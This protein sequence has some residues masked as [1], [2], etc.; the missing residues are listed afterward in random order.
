MALSTD[1]K[2]DI[3]SI[4]KKAGVWLS[5]HHILLY[6]ALAIAG[7]FGVYAIE[8]KIASVAEAKAEAAQ[9]ALAVEKDH[10]A[11]LTAA[12]AT[13]QTQR[14]KENAAF[15]QTISL[16]QSQTKVQIVHDK[17][18]PAPEL[19]HRIE[20]LTGF[21]QDTITLDASQDLIVPLPL[22][23][24]ITARL[25]QGAA[26]AQTVTQQTAVIKNQVATIAEQTNIIT[27]DK[28]VLD[29]TIKA[30]ATE[31]TKV[32][33]DARKSKLKWFGAGVVVGFVG[34]QFAKF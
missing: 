2:T 19:G 30:D 32:K 29:K 7:F 15:L 17:A 14:D 3:Q 21:K 23:Q 5:A 28:A 4:E 18:L 24:D 34:R 12:F 25:D 8:S 31:L 1:V 13:A 27:E 16:L 33:A 10:S 26:D 6:I 11:Q 20:T 9:T 22:A